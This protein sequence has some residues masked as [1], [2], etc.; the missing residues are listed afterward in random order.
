MK[1]LE[2]SHLGSGAPVM[3]AMSAMAP[4]SDRIRGQV[5]RLCGL[6]RHTSVQFNGAGIRYKA[7]FKVYAAGLYLPKKKPAH[8][9]SSHWPCQ[10]PSAFQ[11]PCC[12]KSI[13][14]SWASC[15]LAASKTTWTATAFSQTRA[16]RAA[17]EPDLLGH[18]EAATPATQFMIEWVP[19]SGTV[20]TVKGVVTG[21]AL[22]RAR[23]F[24]RPVAHLA[25]QPS[26][27]TSSSRTRCSARP[28]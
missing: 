6:A 8:R 27:L 9:R 23:V 7:M 22:Q 5:C 1:W 18:Q 28:A 24:Q 20:I 10:A 21:R 14:A 15:F 4:D 11:S 12:A 26:P 2:K 17:H 16:R 19:G 25:R 13:Q 3:L